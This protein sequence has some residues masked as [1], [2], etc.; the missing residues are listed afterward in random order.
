MAP[1]FSRPGRD[2]PSRLRDERGFT[3]SEFVLVAV[4]VIGLA[5]VAMQA[6]QGI[7]KDNA[8]SDCQ[9]ELRSLK[10][11]VERYHANTGEYP[12]D[13]SDLAEVDPVQRRG[14]NWQFEP[15]G[16]ETAPDYVLTSP[17]GC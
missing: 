13:W 3:W 1:S 14:P 15:R 4:F 2:L 12:Q 10:L 11:A 16:K 9:T 5:A 17:I 8:R 6:S 7:R